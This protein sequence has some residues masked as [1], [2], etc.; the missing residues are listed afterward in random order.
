MIQDQFANNGTPIAVIKTVDGI[1]TVSPGVALSFDGSQ[2]YDPDNS[3][4]INYYWWEV[5]GVVENQGSASWNK[6]FIKTFTLPIGVNSKSYQIKL[7]VRD[8]EYVTSSI[9]IVIT[10]HNG[11]NRSEYYLTDHLGSIRTTIDDQGN[12]IG[13][14]DY[15]PFGQVMPGRSSNAGTPNDVNKFTGHER[16]QEGSLNLDYMLARNY[17]PELGRFYSV[18]PLYNKFPAWSPYNYTMNSPLRFTDPDGKSPWPP[19]SG[20]IMAL[21][22][23]DIKLTVSTGLVYGKATAGGLS[24]TKSAFRVADDLINGNDILNDVQLDAHI[25]VAEV[26]DLGSEK[27]S[28]VLNVGGFFKLNF[29]N[30]DG[31]A[32]A[33]NFILEVNI[34]IPMTNMT[35]GFGINTIENEVST[36]LGVGTGL[37]NMV[38]PGASVSVTNVVSYGKKTTNKNDETQK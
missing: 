14:D 24:L 3:N 11:T 26:K 2:S 16:D 21:P 8:N 15:Y 18:D 20:P 31:E 27:D 1:R 30:N 25:A 34:P 6:V 7:T 33:D 22:S 5:D 4:I 37:P 12:V 38:S 9:N 32:D 28:F 29:L 36:S 10:V 19:I 13:Y 17:D 23:K 35:I